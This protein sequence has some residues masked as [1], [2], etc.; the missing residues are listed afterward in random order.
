VRERKI[1]EAETNEKVKVNIMINLDTKACVR[2]E[3]RVNLQ[4]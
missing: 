2:I 3:A 1:N 4:L